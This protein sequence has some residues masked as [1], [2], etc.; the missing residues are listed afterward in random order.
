MKKMFKT[1]ICALTL[2]TAIAAVPAMASA[3]DNKDVDLFDCTW[4]V[5]QD[6]DMPEPC[7][8]G[9]IPISGYCRDDDMPQP[10]TP[11]AIPIPGSFSDSSRDD[12][13][14]EPCTPGSIPISGF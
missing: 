11:G 2:T 14:P 3:R 8:P 7:T 9:S 13:M 5:E 12:D 1:F 6:D 4:A 10:C